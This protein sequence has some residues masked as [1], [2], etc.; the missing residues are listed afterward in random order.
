MVTKQVFSVSLNF[1]RL[2]DAPD[3]LQNFKFLEQ[4]IGE[5]VPRHK[6]S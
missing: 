4:T 1:L 2:N 3:T 6:N 5:I